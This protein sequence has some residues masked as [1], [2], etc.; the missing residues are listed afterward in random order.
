MIWP[1][2]QQ[3]PTSSHD[4]GI[5]PILAKALAPSRR[6]ATTSFAPATRSWPTEGYSLRVA[7]STNGVGLANASIYNPFGFQA[8]GL[9]LPDMH[10]AGLP[11]MNAGRWYPTVTVLANGD[12]LVVSGSIDNTSAITD[13]PRCSSSGAGRGVT[14][15]PRSSAW[16]FTRRCSSR[17]T[18]RSSIRD[19][20]TTT[21]Y[22]DT[23]GTGSVEPGPL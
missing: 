16:T 18:A 19:R 5:P 7:T 10:Q 17:Q 20:R 9:R 22:L 11:D 15:P 8:L 13:C 23:A 2:D 4:P 6:R 12:V 1:G 3:P 14:S 21:R